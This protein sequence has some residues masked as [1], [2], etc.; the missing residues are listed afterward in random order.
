VYPSGQA[1]PASSA[2]SFAAGQTV[3]GLVTAAVGGGSVTV[4]NGSGG[5]V[6]IVADEQGYYIGP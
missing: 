2:V 4:F 5:T 6:Q 1:R 3:A